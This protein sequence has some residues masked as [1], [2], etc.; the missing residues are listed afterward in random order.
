MK[1]LN[2][3]TLVG[4]FVLFA[5]F[6]GMGTI[7]FVA[8]MRLFR[9]EE[10]VVIYFGESVNGLGIGAPVKFKG[11]PIGK[12]KDIRISHNQVQTSGRSF[13]PVFAEIDLTKVGRKLDDAGAVNFSDPEQFRESVRKGLRGQLQ[14]LSFITGQL[15]VE[16][17][18]LEEPGSLYRQ[19]QIQP[20]FLEIPSVR[21]DMEEFGTTASD[22]MAKFAAVDV[23][24]ISA[25]LLSL[26]KRLDEVVATIDAEKWNSAVIETADS[27]NETMPQ[28][29]ATLESMQ[30]L[31]A[32]LEGAIDPAVENYH[33]T[34]ANI[35]DTLDRS[36][37]VLSNMETISAPDGRI[38]RE[39]LQTMDALQQASK[40]AEEFLSFIERNPSAI[41]SG[42]SQ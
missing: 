28:L 6:L 13:I 42:R 14:L 36:N 24:A 33:D 7:I 27:M 3:P 21:S 5:A 23:E 11:V 35:R 32:K 30:A 19:L 9:A 39:L 12:V 15:Y 8:S 40:S 17:D 25:N 16:L 29:R 38:Q 22:I 26:I 31:T 37:A 2:N 4:L 20:E 18:F 34:L 41:I 10:T 1:R